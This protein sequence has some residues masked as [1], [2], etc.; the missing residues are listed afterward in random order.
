[1]SERTRQ[2]VARVAARQRFVAVGNRF[3]LFFLV[4]AAL[5]MTALLFARLLALIPDV[6][7]WPTIFLPPVAALLLAVL[8]HRRATSRDIARLIDHRTDSNDLFLTATMIDSAVGEYQTI[9]VRQAD[10]RA[11]K[12]QPQSVVN[13]RWGR[14]ARDAAIIL[15]ILVLSA[16]FLP[17][18]DP[19]GKQD[20]RKKLVER[21]KKLAETAKATALRAEMIE[22]K[23]LSG[24]NSKEV[25][26]AL[27]DLKL[28]L[29]EQ[30]PGD[31]QAN[32]KRLAEEQKLLGQMWREANEEKMKQMGDREQSPQKFGSN[33]E[34]M[35]QWKSELD[36]GKVDGLKREL[37]ELK[38]LAKQI[39]ESKSD[40][41]K[42]QL[43][44]EM[45]ERLQALADFAAQNTSSDALKSALQRAME[46]SDLSKFSELSKEAMQNL[47]ESL[48]LT[49]QELQ[50]L[51]QNLR[52]AQSL[53]QALQ[54]VQ[55]A[56]FAQK[57]GD[58]GGT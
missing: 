52:D 41:E 22:K 17:Q 28:A 14:G 51:A 1:M 13:F 39:E 2:L 7:T 55:M 33:S 48:G 47:Q 3:Q 43:E 27:Q 58:P 38:K 24:E 36:K 46:Q 50:Q 8:F 18:F 11:S 21:K 16:M 12:I 35:S 42:Q 20:E 9:V 45:K 31:V 29:Q 32:L 40:A 25:A 23:D 30:K 56:K 37:D 49:E 54:I 26:K 34:K 4:F 10:D 57:Q 44:K 15:P 6:F 5:Y 19:F 53:E